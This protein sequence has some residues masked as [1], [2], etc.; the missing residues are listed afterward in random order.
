MFSHKT[1]ENTSWIPCF[2]AENFNFP[3]WHWTFMKGKACAPVRETTWM[4]PDW[5]HRRNKQEHTRARAWLL[6][7]SYKVC[8]GCLE[9]AR[10][11]K[12]DN[13]FKKQW[14]QKWGRKSWGGEEET[15]SGG[16]MD[17]SQR[18]SVLWT[19]DLQAVELVCVCWES[20]P[21]YQC[22]F[23]PSFSQ[24]LFSSGEPLLFPSGDI[25]P[26]QKGGGMKILRYCYKSS[27]HALQCFTQHWNWGGCGQW[28]A[29]DLDILR[30]YCVHCK[31]K[32]W[33]K[34][35]R[36]LNMTGLDWES[37][38]CARTNYWD[39]PQGPTLSV[40]P[41]PSSLQRSQV[42]NKLECPI[43]RVG[44]HR[45]GE[46][47]FLLLC[48]GQS[49]WTL[50]RVAIHHWYSWLPSNE[51]PTLDVVQLK[52][53]TSTSDSVAVNIF[54]WGKT[55]PKNQLSPRLKKDYYCRSWELLEL[56]LPLQ[57]EMCLLHRYSCL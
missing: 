2:E 19:S 18:V 25:P 5:E 1:L 3:G 54:L 32:I 10:Q 29:R 42:K 48:T 16:N 36:Y 14:R 24:W 55:K 27:H 49:L 44:E 13:E 15:R 46:E 11:R 23:L 52:V 39:N 21:H 34:D 26:T 53:K 4:P 57:H 12:R 20:E 33:T 41:G 50:R 7:A 22:I 9:F 35:W 51:I 43:S 47:T 6:Q 45:L 31:S 38:D 8:G 30:T 37:N 17:T 28:E 40:L 56:S